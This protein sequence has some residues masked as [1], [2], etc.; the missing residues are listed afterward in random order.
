M[1]R[2]IRSVDDYQ[3]TRLFTGALARRQN[4]AVANGK[5]NEVPRSRTKSAGPSAGNRFLANKSDQQADHQLVLEDITSPESI[6]ALIAD[7]LASGVGLTFGVTQDRRSI[8]IGFYFD[9]ER[10]TWYIQSKADWQ[11]MVQTIAI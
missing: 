2:S 11:E 3:V 6:L 8:T 7:C 10:N 1:L 5:G 9:G 4:S